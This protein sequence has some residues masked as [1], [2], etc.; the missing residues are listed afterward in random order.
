MILPLANLEPIGPFAEPRPSMRG[1]YLIR[2]PRKARAIG[3]M[4]A[5]L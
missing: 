3:A 1:R 5:L 4:D 2:D